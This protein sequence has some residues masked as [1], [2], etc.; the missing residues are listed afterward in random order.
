MQPV[1]LDR[2]QAVQS[3]RSAANARSHLARFLGF[4]AARADGVRR[5]GLF[6]LLDGPL[7]TGFVGFLLGER[8]TLIT[9]L[10]ITRGLIGSYALPLIGADLLRVLAFYG[11]GCTSPR[12][13]AA[14]GLG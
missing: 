9:S 14:I 4:C 5:R 12:T 3:R 11:Q 10:S 7:V 6:V 8:G 2:P 13:A 1:N